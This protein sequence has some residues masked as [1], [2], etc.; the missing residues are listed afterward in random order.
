[1]GK[2]SKLSFTLIELLV[3]IAIIAI[4]AALLLPGLSRSKNVAK[5]IA[6][7]GNLKQIGMA[8]ISYAESSNGALAPSFYAISG[9]WL[10][11]FAQQSLAADSKLGKSSDWRYYDTPG[12]GIPGAA[13][14][15]S[16]FAKC[17]SLAGGAY[18][19]GPVDISC[20]GLNGFHGA[21]TPHINKRMLSDIKRPSETMSFLDCAEPSALRSTWYSFCQICIPGTR[22][23]DPRHL[24]GS[25]MVLFDGHVEWQ[26][27]KFY[28]SVGSRDIWLH[29]NPL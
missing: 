12:S 11:P 5:R 20:Y 15:N 21:F 9:D 3:V 25:N 24:N 2:L 27:M 1:M 29:L 13:Y 8:T 23:A 6:C 10:A 7:V 4:L 26:P 18:S 22:I 19:S 14:E 17:P 16:L 28:L